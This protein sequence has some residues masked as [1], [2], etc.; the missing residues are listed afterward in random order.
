MAS[1]GICYDRLYIDYNEINNKSLD[2]HFDSVHC[3]ADDSGTCKFQHQLCLEL[4]NSV[5]GESCFTEVLSHTLVPIDLP[6]A[7][8]SLNEVCNEDVDYLNIH[9][10]GGRFRDF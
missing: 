6:A 3:Y 2:L 7:S 1:H 4:I 10:K 8:S 9:K 5:N